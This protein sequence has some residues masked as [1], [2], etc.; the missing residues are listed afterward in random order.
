MC[1]YS[2]YFAFFSNV[3]QGE[4]REQVLLKRCS[5]VTQFYSAQIQNYFDICKFLNAFLG[6]IV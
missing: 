3:V 2:M 1:F 4:W 6:Q 5:R